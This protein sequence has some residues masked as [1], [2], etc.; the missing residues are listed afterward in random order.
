MER[1]GERVYGFRVQKGRRH[2]ERVQGKGFE[3]GRAGKFRLQRPEFEGKYYPPSGPAR[4]QWK[5]VRGKSKGA[6]D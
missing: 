3:R 5:A 1:E 6:G 2:G 4:G